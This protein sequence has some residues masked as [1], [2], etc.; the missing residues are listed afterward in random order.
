ML[1]AQLMKSVQPLIYKVRLD[2]K[3]I[4]YKVLRQVEAVKKKI[5]PIDFSPIKEA[6]INN[7]K[8][9][10]Q[11]EEHLKNDGLIVIFPSDQ[12]ISK[13]NLSKKFN[14]IAETGNNL[15]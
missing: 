6:L 1:L 10:K 5:L 7:I 2:Y 14:Q 4:T 8:S 13:S 9:R 15:L 3:M 11:T 12:I